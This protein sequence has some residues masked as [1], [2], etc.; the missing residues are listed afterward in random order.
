M[1]I[2]RRF[3]QRGNIYFI[4]NVTYDRRP[5]LVQNADSLLE[6]IEAIHTKQPFDLQAWVILPDHFHFVIDPMDWDFSRLMQSIKM[7]SGARY[8]KG[9]GVKSGRLWQNRFWDHIIRDQEDLNRH[10]DYVHYNPVK[11]QL[12]KSPFDWKWTSIH[13]YYREGLYRR[14]WG[15]KEIDWGEEDFGE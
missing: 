6:S 11:H 9:V 8:R 4:A 12:V 1:S 2:L 3:S 5:L 7:S 10:I 14:D 15:N 13:E